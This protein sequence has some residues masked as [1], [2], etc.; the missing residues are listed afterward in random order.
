MSKFRTHYDNL[1]IQKTAPIEVIRAAYRGLSQKYHP[2]RNQNDPEAGRIMALINQS[3]ETLSDPVKRRKHDI[4]IEEQEAQ[5][6]QRA[7]QEQ[8]AQQEQR[9]QQEQRARQEQRA[10]QEQRARQ[11]QRAQQEQRTQQEQRARQEQKGSDGSIFAN[12]ISIIEFSVVVIIILIIIIS[13]SYL[14]LFSNNKSKDDEYSTV[15][16]ASESVLLADEEANIEN[17]KTTYST[18]FDC[19]KAKSLTENLICNN[20]HLAIADLELASLLKQAKT[21]VTDKKALN[22]RVRKQWNYREKNCK[23]EACLFEW[24]NYQ[25]IVLTQIIE[26]GNVN[27]GLTVKELTPEPLPET[28]HTDNSNFEGVAPLQIKTP[29]T[30]NHYFVKIENAYTHTHL[31]SYFIQSGDVLEINLPLGTY[32]IKYASG[33]QWYGPKNLFGPETTYAKADQNFNFRFD[34]YQYTGYTVELIE[35][36]NGNLKTSNIDQSQF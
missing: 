15:S 11:E 12:F 10:Q 34:G 32:N 17:S 22:N 33:E 8:R 29:S 6:E 36:I 28:G 7:R 9:T 21:T 23:D 2:D 20:E 13:I 27:A 1:K 25:K 4:W 3:Y 16:D 24:F 31:V 18:S 26:T 19:N 14:L 35:Q 30:G 5:Q